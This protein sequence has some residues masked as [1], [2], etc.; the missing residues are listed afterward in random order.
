MSRGLKNR[1]VQLIALGGTIGTGLF[2]G[3]G[4]SI[5]LA[6]PSIILAYGIAGLACFLLMRALGELLVS[7]VESNSFVFFIKKYLGEKMGFVIGWT[8]WMC[9]IAIA[10]AE[11]TASG[12]YVQFWFPN[13]PIWLTG[14]VLLLILFIIN[15]VAVSAFGETEF[16]LAIIKI[17]AIVALILIGIVLVAIHYKTPYGHASLM[18]VVDGGF[19]ATGAK[20]FVLSFQMVLFSFAG[21]EMIGMTASETQDPLVTIPKS[22]NEVPTRV[23]LFYI[24]SLLALMSIFPWQHVSPTS[25]PFVQV[26]AGVGIR[27]A[28][29]IIN[30]VVLTAAI[31]ACNS[32]LFT[33]GRMLFS[34]TYNGKSKFSQKVGSLS[35]RQ[36]PFNAILFSTAVIAVIVLLS[37]MMPGD[38]FSFISSVATTCFLFVWGMIVL[39]HLKYRRSI[40]KA[41]RE[42]K[43]KFKMP[44]FPLTDYFVLIFMVFVAFVLTLKTDTLIAL[45]GSV[46]WLIGLFVFKSLTDKVKDIEEE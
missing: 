44:L 5:H 4:Q 8:Y 17:V 23:L 29:V 45:V 15:I 34:L 14:L 19:F 20:G 30:F 1:H 40:Q 37:I 10:M 32:S 13:I 33:T 16:W 36:I 39:A 18:N 9:W 24:G 35:R 41:G 46:I 28:A 42:K 11:V 26:F 22:I 2:L 12:L 3:A 21:I 27:S 31:S 6:G 25:S 38:V 7:D 43:L